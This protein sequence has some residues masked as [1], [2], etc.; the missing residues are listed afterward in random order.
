[1]PDIEIALTHSEL[2]R[3]EKAA[4]ARGVTVEQLAADELRERY[5]LHTSGGQVVPLRHRAKKGERGHG[6]D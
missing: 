2:E 5:A 3:L 4:A 6:C 1:M